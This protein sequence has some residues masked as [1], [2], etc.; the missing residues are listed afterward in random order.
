MRACFEKFR[1]GF[2]CCFAKRDIVSLIFSRS[3]GGVL[4][5][6]IIKNIA[7]IVSFAFVVTA[8][9]DV[10]AASDLKQGT[11]VQATYQVTV[12]TGLTPEDGTLLSGG[13]SAPLLQE[14]YVLGLTKDQLSEVVLLTESAR[15][16]QTLDGKEPIGGYFFE[17]LIV[18]KQENSVGLGWNG[19]QEAHYQIWWNGLTNEMLINPVSAKAM[20]V[21]ID[22]ALLGQ[23]ASLIDQ[24]LLSQQWSL[25]LFGGYSTVVK[26]A[27]APAHEFPSPESTVTVTMLDQWQMASK[28]G[29]VQTDFLPTTIRLSPNQPEDRAPERLQALFRVQSAPINFQAVPVKYQI[30]EL[31]MING[32][33]RVLNEFSNFDDALRGME[34]PSGD[35]LPWNEGI[36]ASSIARYCLTHSHDFPFLMNAPADDIEIRGQGEIKAS[37][38]NQRGYQNQRNFQ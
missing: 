11:G 24:N 29:R 32:K 38:S 10:D 13:A 4:M 17:V 34:I 16:A 36:L 33:E 2:E 1:K 19:I 26:R 35:V 15:P 22:P 12:G 18:P 3:F 23:T 5:K 20:N 6:Q 28:V 25:W 27:A 8:T 14:R 37:T 30:I 9:L 7:V 31:D 21:P